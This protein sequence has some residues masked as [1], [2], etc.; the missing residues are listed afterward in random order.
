MITIK[1]LSRDANGM[2]VHQIYDESGIVFGLTHNAGFP[3][4][5]CFFPC[6][7]YGD[8]E[9]IYYEELKEIVRF[10]ETGKVEGEA[11]RD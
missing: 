8:P 10:L 7:F 2:S 9:E 4:H 5:A 11:H 1:E 6:D 3:E